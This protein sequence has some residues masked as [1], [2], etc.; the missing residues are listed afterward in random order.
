M[1]HTLPRLLAL[2]FLLAFPVAKSAAQSQHEMNAT[3]RAD[4]EKADAELN[5]I[6]KK[7]VATLD[8]AGHEKLKTVQR[9]WVVWRDAEAD[10]QADQEAR[11]GSMEP[12]I[13][14]GVAADLT[15]AR[16]KQLRQMLKPGQ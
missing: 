9:A 14:S 1:N 8:A 7:V 11:G 4:F 10:F 15:R 6:Y 5:R 16:I 2:L 13:V 12:M 3:A